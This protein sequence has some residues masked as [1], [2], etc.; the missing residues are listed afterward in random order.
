MVALL[1]FNHFISTYG[2]AAIFLLSVLQ[3]MCI[4]T[5]SELT[6]GFAGVLAAEG[7]LNLVGVIAVA[8]AG[9]LIGAYLAWFIGRYAGRGF[10]DRYGRYVLLTHHDLDRAEGWYERHGAWGVFVGRL[11]PVIR[12]FVALPA[13]V[14]EYP[15]VPF[16]I[17]TFLGSLIWLSTMALIGY[18]VGSSYHQVMKGFSYAGY[19]LAAAAVIAIAFV[20]AHRYRRYQATVGGTAGAGG[21]G[22]GERAPATSSAAARASAAAARATAARPPASSRTPAP[23]R[24]TGSR[25][26]DPAIVPEGPVNRRR[27]A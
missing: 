9:E 23:S 18:G 5:S 21:A 7:Q 10:V 1:S 2:Y 19:L 4:P 8:V 16:G 22:A 20:I 27:Q 26:E 25:D 6:L 11:I 13:G 15:L 24:T 3:S 17:L 14:A 12:N